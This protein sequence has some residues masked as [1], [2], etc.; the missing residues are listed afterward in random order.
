M[1]VEYGGAGIRVNAILPG[2]INTPMSRAEMLLAGKNA[3]EVDGR[4]PLLSRWGTAEEVAA[5]ALFFASDDS[6]YITGQGLLVDGGFSVAGTRPQE[7]E[8]ADLI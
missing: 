6:S 3:L 1:A 2:A 7:A 5:T 8:P 4:V